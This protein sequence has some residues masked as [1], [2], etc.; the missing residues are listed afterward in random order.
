MVRGATATTAVRKLECTPTRPPAMN[1]I[2]VGSQRQRN[3]R[4]NF[5]PRFDTKDDAGRTMMRPCDSGRAEQFTATDSCRPAA[6]QGR[7]HGG[8]T[9]TE[10]SPLR[11]SS[12]W[13][14]RGELLGAA[15][16]DV[17]HRVHVRDCM[18]FPRHHRHSSCS[19]HGDACCAGGQTRPAHAHRDHARQCTN[20][21]GEP[22]GAECKPTGHASPLCAGCRHRRC[23]PSGK[24]LASVQLDPAQTVRSAQA[25]VAQDDADLA[26]EL[27][28]S[29][30]TTQS[31]DTVVAVLSSHRDGASINAAAKASG[32]NYRTA[33]RIVEAAA[34]RRQFLVAS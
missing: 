14:I 29:G 20:S 6:R 28:A 16:S 32:I 18:G 26:S 2:V 4:R 17:R 27:I 23:K 15:R 19:R 9:T 21:G 25:E 31:R 30:V 22:G 7:P 1:A 12:V 10:Q 33:Q 5:A 34:E 13:S 8:M 3:R 24:G 11:D